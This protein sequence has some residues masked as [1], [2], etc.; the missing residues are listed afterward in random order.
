MMPSHIIENFYLDD[1]AKLW[2]NEF[3]KIAQNNI[4]HRKVKIYP[5]RQ[6][7]YHNRHKL[8]KEDIVC[9]NNGIDLSAIHYQCFSQKCKDVK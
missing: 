5:N 6:A 9:G 7:F 3:L 8:F 1:G 2:T 4:L